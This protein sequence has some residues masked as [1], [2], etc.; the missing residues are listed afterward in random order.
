ME[1]KD[2][3]IFPAMVG[4][5]IIIGQESWQIGIG[6]LLIAYAVMGINK[7]NT[8]HAISKKLWEEKVKTEE[9]AERKQALKEE[10]ERQ[11]Q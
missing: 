5:A 3:T 2:W 11:Q 1:Q 6:V 7:N 4:G 8:K 9:E 10:R